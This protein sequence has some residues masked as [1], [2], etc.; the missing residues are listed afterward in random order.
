MKHAFDDAYQSVEGL[1]RCDHVCVAVCSFGRLMLGLG[2]LDMTLLV[3]ARISASVIPS[4]S[5][6]AVVQR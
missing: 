2:C 4:R 1:L 3:V 6:V 5:V